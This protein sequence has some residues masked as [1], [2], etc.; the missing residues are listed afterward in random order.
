[1]VRPTPSSVRKEIS[2]AETQF[3][4]ELDA[5]SNN[6]KIGQLNQIPVELNT[7]QFKAWMVSSRLSLQNMVACRTAN[8]CNLIS[9][10]SQQPDNLSLSQ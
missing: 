2:E 4:M 5:G 8:L 7:T 9:L 3:R 6:T 1:M 10:S